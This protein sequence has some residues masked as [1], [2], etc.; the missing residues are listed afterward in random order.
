VPKISVDAKL[1][2]RTQILE[3]AK[4]C[5]SKNG[6]D[7]TSID[8]ICQRAGL[9]KGAVYLYFKTKDELIWSMIANQAERLSNLSRTDNSKD[10]LEPLRVFLNAALKDT[11]GM[12]LELYTLVKAISDGE[13]RRRYLDNL[14][15]IN[16]I[17][18]KAVDQTAPPHGFVKRHGTEATAEILET[19]LLG[20]MVRCS[21]SELS[22][23]YDHLILMSEILLEE[24]H[25]GES[26]GA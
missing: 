11:D 20:L 19:M 9:S 16:Q 15:I 13:T 25:T 21:F 23:R 5:F 18:S 2:R 26:A 14:G 4:V 24:K 22:P 6:Y 3:A 7:Q 12:R 17:L 10:K 1:K 8:D